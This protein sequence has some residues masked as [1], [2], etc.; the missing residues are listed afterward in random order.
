MKWQTTSFCYFLPVVS[1]KARLFI[2]Y[3][4]DR[5][6]RSAMDRPD[7]PRCENCQL[8][9]SHLS[10]FSPSFPSLSRVTLSSLSVSAPLHSNTLNM[11]S[12]NSTAPPSALGE[13][14]VCGKE[15]STRC[16]KCLQGGVNWMY[17]CSPEHQKLVSCAVPVFIEFELTL[18]SLRLSL[19]FPSASPFQIWAVHKRICG[20]PFQWPALTSKEAAEML[21]LATFPIPGP[22]GSRTWLDSMENGA[23]ESMLDEK[24]EPLTFDVTSAFAVSQ[25]VVFCEARSLQTELCL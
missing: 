21:Q 23:A 16:S 8:S 22:A 3:S 11:S 5:R 20:A 10:S 13:C 17:F 12:S 15:A 2:K 9:L 6:C 7:F 4:R 25:S 1:P 19:G 24:G 18:L 14:V